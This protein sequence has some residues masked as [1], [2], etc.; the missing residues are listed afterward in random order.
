MNIFLI[1]II[2]NMTLVHFSYHWQFIFDEMEKH[3]K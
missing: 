2:N 3:T 1:R